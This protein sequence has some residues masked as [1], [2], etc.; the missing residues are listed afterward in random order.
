MSERDLTRERTKYLT[1]LCH[2]IDEFLSWMDM[3]MKKPSSHERG[4]RIATACNALDLVNQRAKLFGLPRRKGRT[5]PRA[6]A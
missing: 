5:K 4:S 6:A 1:L 2:N 3:E